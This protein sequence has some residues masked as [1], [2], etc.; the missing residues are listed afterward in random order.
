MIK[1]L[2]KDTIV[3]LGIVPEKDCKI[4]QTRP[5]WDGKPKIYVTSEPT[6]ADAETQRSMISME[7]VMGIHCLAQ[8]REK[9]WEIARRA[10][11]AV[12]E[13][14]TELE[15]TRGSGILC[16]TYIEHNVFQHQER[17]DCYIAFFSFR[18]LTTTPNH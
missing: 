2:A 5:Y 13:K 3:A 8:T 16:I 7:T 18:V 15:Q 14:F 4:D 1:E 10:V 9:A 11:S 6:K 17:S 12:Y